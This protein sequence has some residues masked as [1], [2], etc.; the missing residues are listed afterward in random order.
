MYVANLAMLSMPFG[1]EWN[2]SAKNLQDELQKR[3]II[4]PQKLYYEYKLPD[5]L[6]Q[7]EFMNKLTMESF[8]HNFYSRFA[9]P[10]LKD[11]D[12][13]LAE[14]TKI[15]KYVFGMRSKYKDFLKK[16]EAEIRRKNPELANIQV[17][18]SRSIVYG[19][20][21]GFAP[22]EIAYFSDNIH[23][24]RAKEQQVIDLLKNQ[25]DIK[26]N[27]VLAP[28]T[29]EMVINALQQNMLSKAKER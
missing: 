4:L 2:S 16:Y 5:G 19:A 18:D 10:I 13:S 8:A 22:Q 9:G 25:F 1:R 7:V 3:G 15:F 24:N 20:L 17:D 14:K 21:F 26:L 6:G 28:K 23:R 27:Y 29:A 12:L 11:K